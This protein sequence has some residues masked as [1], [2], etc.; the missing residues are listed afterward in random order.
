MF[1]NLKALGSHQAIQV[2][3]IQASRHITL[4]LIALVPWY[5]KNETSHKDLKITTVDQLAKVYYHRFHSNLQYHLYLNANT[6]YICNIKNKIEFGYFG[7]FVYYIKRKS[8]S[9]RLSDFKIFIRY[10]G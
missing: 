4:R 5:V 3:T 7:C 1:F 10:L 6:V 2:H 8:E 9:K